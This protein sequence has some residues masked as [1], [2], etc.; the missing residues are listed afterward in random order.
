MLDSLI[1]SK[2]RLKLLVKFFIN[3]QNT[4]YLRGLESEFGE[5]TNAIRQEL[6]RLEEVGLLI[7]NNELN[8]KVFRAN[9]THPWYGDIHH[10]LLKYTGIDQIVDEVVK[11]VGQLQRAYV[12]GD[13]ARGIPGHQ[14]DLLLVGDQFDLD[15][16]DRLVEKAEKLVSFKVQLKTIAP[17]AEESLLLQIKAF[18]P[19]WGER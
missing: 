8:R 2:T 11:R 17:A 6:N 14:L 18:I 3:A 4:G 12:T 10:L 9:T 19:V 13:F 16:L 5:S 7:S 15:Y 1:T